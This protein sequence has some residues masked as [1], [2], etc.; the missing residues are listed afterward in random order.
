MDEPITDPLI[1]VSSP[2]DDSE[3]WR[4]CARYLKNIRSHVAGQMQQ[5][6]FRVVNAEDEDGDVPVSVAGQIMMD[7]QSLI[8]HEGE[9]IVRQE[10]RTQ[11]SLPEGIG[12]RFVLRM[13]GQGAGSRRDGTLLEDALFRVCAELDRANL[14][15]ATP[16][17]VSNHVEAACRRSIARD[18][19]ALWEHL[20]GYVLTYGVEG[21]MHRFRM[22]ASKA[23]EAEASA[24]L[25]SVPSALIGVVR[26]DPERPRRWLLSNGRDDV[27]LRF[28]DSVPAS[29]IDG[30]QS[31]GPLIA[32]G[33]VDL[34]GDGE[35]AGMREVSGCYVFPLVKFRRI[36]TAERDLLL[37]NPVLACPGY[38]AAKGVWTLSNEDIGIDV[39]K[40]SWDEAV[41]AFHEYFMFLWETY[42]E[43]GDE[44]EGEE[45]EV[46]TFLKSLAFP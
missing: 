22:N 15:S 18:V 9:L 24:D 37:L 33:K 4:A 16:E 43:S 6:N 8:S 34:D 14:Y 20:R 5:F 31:A 10:L 46:S 38:N 42:V 35:L 26:R 1:R 2:G 11:N 7:V 17:E 40:P 44:F 45:L 12:K 13:E 3:Y 29:E 23:L 32:T 25:A 36:I 21:G 27:P 30:Y 19:L 28:L 39:S 41:W